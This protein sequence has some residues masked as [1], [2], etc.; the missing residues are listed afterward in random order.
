MVFKVGDI[1]RIKNSA[2]Y[3]VWRVVGNY[4]GGENQE[5]VIEIETLDLIAN[6]QGRMCVPKV[7][8]ETCMGAA[9]VE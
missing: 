7:I 4:L 3:R 6:T 2:G 1:I 9:V 5:D 8:L